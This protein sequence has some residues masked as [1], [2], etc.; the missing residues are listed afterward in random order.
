MRW[1][2]DDEHYDRAGVSAHYW[3]GADGPELG[4]VS[5]H[6]RTGPQVLLDDVE[7]VGRR[8]SV[9]EAELLRYAEDHPLEVLYSPY[10]NVGS[11]ELNVWVRAERVGDGT[12]TG[13]LCCIEQWECSDY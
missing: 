9:V 1:E 3:E 4:A 13:A 8:P 6:G 12:I 5:V 2:L 7:L 10:G 11:A